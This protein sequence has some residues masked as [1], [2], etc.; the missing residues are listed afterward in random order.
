MTNNP[1]HFS[2][3]TRKLLAKRREE[4][5]GE[6]PEAAGSRVLPIS[7]IVGSVSK[8][9]ISESTCPGLF[10]RKEEGPVRLPAEST[11]I[12][13]RKKKESREFCVYSTQ[14]P[15]KGQIPSAACD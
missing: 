1:D 14:L 2:Q 3:S 7:R 5:S 13:R 6:I 8:Y 11:G 9:L 15:G 4:C 10:P 12:F